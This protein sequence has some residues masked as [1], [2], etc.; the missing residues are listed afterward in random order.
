MD[1][2]SSE[3]SIHQLFFGQLTLGKLFEEKSRGVGGGSE[4][5][6]AEDPATAVSMASRRPR[7]SEIVMAL[8][9]ATV[10]I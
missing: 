1:R 8:A 4:A 7:P 10:D 6:S 2:S 9:A 5:L 3:D